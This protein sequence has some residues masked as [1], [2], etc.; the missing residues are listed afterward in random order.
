MALFRRRQYNYDLQGHAEL[1]KTQKE[2]SR[3]H[4]KLFVIFGIPIITVVTTS[5]LVRLYHIEGPSMEPTLSNNQ[6]ILIE[7]WDK[8]KAKL[9]GAPFEPK[10]YDIVVLKPPG[11]KSQ[12][13]KRIIGMPGDEIVIVGGNVAVINAE[14][15]EGYQVDLAAPN[16]ALQ[17]ISDTD[18]EVDKKLGPDQY[19][20]LGDNRAVSEDSRVFGPV[21]AKDIVGKIWKRI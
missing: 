16:G 19:Y 7:K 18:G 11:E 1:E 13:I 2:K 8:T 5:F 4:F 10:R 20:V 6:R 14:H 15:P 21:S 12:I 9:T 3:L 17:Y